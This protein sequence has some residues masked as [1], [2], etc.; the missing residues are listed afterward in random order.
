MFSTDLL[1]ITQ[2][3]SRMECWHCKFKC[4]VYK[5]K[6]ISD[7]GK[8]VQEMRAD[9]EIEQNYVILKTWTFI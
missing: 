1:L 3:S 9:F 4:N 7:L 5:N 6:L 8:T 2:N